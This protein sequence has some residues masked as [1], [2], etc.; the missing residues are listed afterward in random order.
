MDARTARRARV[1]GPA[2]KLIPQSDLVAA[3]AVDL[4]RQR[5]TSRHATA[6]CRCENHL[7]LDSL[8]AGYTN[9]DVHFSLNQTCAPSSTI[10][11]LH[12]LNLPQPHKSDRPPLVICVS[13][14]SSRSWLLATDTRSSRLV[15]YTGKSKKYALFIANLR[16]ICPHFLLTIV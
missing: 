15:L 14:R 12:H 16:A 3:M 9:V 1:N 2:C 7:S 6:L 10:P 4:R 11:L 8:C 13:P 5:K